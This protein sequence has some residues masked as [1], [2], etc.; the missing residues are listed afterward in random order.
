MFIWDLCGFISDPCA[1][2]HA[3]FL[4]HLLLTVVIGIPIIGAFLIGYGSLSLIYGYVLIFDSL[5]CLGHSN[6]EIIPHQV[7][8]V[9][10]FLR[11]IILTPT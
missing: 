1:A 11:Y 7:F 4:E 10:P 8:D 3:T 9:I 2:G 5:R 6:A